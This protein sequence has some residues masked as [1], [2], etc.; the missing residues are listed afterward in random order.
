[1]QRTPPNSQPR[2]WKKPHPKAH[3]IGVWNA[4]NISEASRGNKRYISRI[5][6][7]N[8]SFQ[9]QLRGRTFKILMENYFLSRNQQLIISTLK[10][11]GQNK[12][13]FRHAAFQKINFEA[14]RWFIPPDKRKPRKKLWDAGH[15]GLSLGAKEVPKRKAREE[16][17]L[18]DKWHWEATCLWISENLEVNSWLVLKNQAE[19]VKAVVNC[20]GKQSYTRKEKVLVCIIFYKVIMQTLNIDLRIFCLGGYAE[21]KREGALSEKACM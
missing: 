5:R 9:Q 3:T 20:R 19:W 8:P 16:M 12:G 17:W 4:K 1:M 6:N 7:Y 18:R 2:E 14:T 15:R 13:I 11:E 10:C 21:E